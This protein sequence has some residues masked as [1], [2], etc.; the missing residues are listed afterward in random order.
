MSRRF[1]SPHVGEEARRKLERLQMR[2]GESVFAFNSYFS[3]L[4]FDVGEMDQRTQMSYY[5]RA[6][7][8]QV[9]LK[10]ENNLHEAETVAE[11]M[12]F[13]LVAEQKLELLRLKNESRAPSKSTTSK[14]P[15]N[16]KAQPAKEA[17][18]K[19]YSEESKAPCGYCNL[20]GHSE[21]DCRFKEKGI[22]RL[23][24]PCGQCGNQTH[25]TTKC[26]AR[27]FRNKEKKAAN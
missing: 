17:P 7:S 2:H 26:K 9:Y 19:P 15:T 5:L 27:G 20:K 25:E 21:P 16:G 13:A 14:E 10:L 18:K 3:T 24:K 6:L 11:L 4:L 12:D 23:D 8:A 1:V 22:P